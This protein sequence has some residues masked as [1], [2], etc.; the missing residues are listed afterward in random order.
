MISGLLR[1]INGFRKPIFIES[2]QG[3]FR[4]IMCVGRDEQGAQQIAELFESQITAIW[5]EL[6]LAMQEGFDGYDQSDEFPPAVFF[7]TIG[8]TTDGAFM[9]DTSS[10]YLT[11]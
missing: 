8:R 5:P 10:Y 2:Q 1:K 6:F 7:L 4:V 11:F 3:G 9:G